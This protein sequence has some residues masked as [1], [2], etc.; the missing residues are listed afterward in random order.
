VGTYAPDLLGLYDMAVPLTYLDERPDYAPL[1][2]ASS[3]I[4]HRSRA[5]ISRAMQV[6]G[7]AGLGSMTRSESEGERN[8][9]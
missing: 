8:G 7:F 9:L 2:A 4:W 1:R 5:A 3:T 6:A